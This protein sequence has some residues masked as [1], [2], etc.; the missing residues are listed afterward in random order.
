MSTTSL[1]ALAAKR[2]E[3]NRFVQGLDA[4]VR[5]RVGEGASGDGGFAKTVSWVSSNLLCDLRTILPGSIPSCDALGL[6][7][8]ARQN[9]NEY[10]RSYDSRRVPAKGFA[11]D[12]VTGFMDD[13]SP[14]DDILKALGEFNGPL[15][16]MQASNEGYKSSTEGGCGISDSVVRELPEPAVEWGEGLYPDG[17]LSD[18]SSDG[19]EQEGI[20]SEA[21]EIGGAG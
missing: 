15:R 20:C 13:G 18:L 10:R 2:R 14:I 8:W 3:D 4:A 19:Q 1:T 12:S 16:T 17:E 21:E 6:L 5:A 11:G 7:I 9:Q